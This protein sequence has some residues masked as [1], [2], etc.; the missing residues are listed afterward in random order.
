MAN[1]FFPF[2]PH[3]FRVGAAEKLTLCATFVLKGCDFRAWTANFYFTCFFFFAKTAL[4][5]LG[6]AGC[7]FFPPA[8]VAF[9]VT[10]NF[11]QPQC[12][13]MYIIYKSHPRGVLFEER[14]VAVLGRIAA[15]GSKSMRF[16]AVELAVSSLPWL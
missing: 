9:P 7:F 15:K 10:N 13:R 12:I 4:Q 1:G 16:A 5:K 14:S 6:D 2:P 11:R 3:G 8:K